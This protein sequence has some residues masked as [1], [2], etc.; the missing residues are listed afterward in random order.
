[1]L[2]KDNCDAISSIFIQLFK[3]KLNLAKS[4]PNAILL[5]RW[6]YNYRDLYGVQLQAKLSN[7]L[8]ALNHQSLLGKVTNIRLLQIQS[9]YGLDC[10]PV[11]SW[12]LDSI[13]N[14]TNITFLEGL[15][16][17]C[18]KH[19]FSYS[20]PDTYR[21]VILGGNTPIRNILN[22]QTYS[23]LK[24]FLVQKRIIYKSQL[25]EVITG[26]ALSWSSFCQ[27]NS[28]LT[29]VTPAAWFMLLQ[30]TFPG[31]PIFS[32]TSPFRSNPVPLPPTLPVDFDSL[33][34]PS[35]H[36]SCA[37]LDLFNYHQ[38]YLTTPRTNQSIW[39]VTWSSFIF[40][41]VL[42]RITFGTDWSSLNY[43]I[44]HWIVTLLPMSSADLLLP[45]LTMI[46]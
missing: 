39:A 20:V 2:T 26:C 43:K 3:A 42:V 13:I 4:T 11:I 5:N 17:L 24:N 16:T 9:K 6:I 23:R 44:E 46:F 29:T 30:A 15:L 12:P 7:F 38:L 41:P 34:L 10:N 8:I 40:S 37:P 21:N 45:L 1:I 28:L 25:S 19:N 33:S 31:Q 22:Q 14:R 32:E 35:V 18:K 36:H 27:S